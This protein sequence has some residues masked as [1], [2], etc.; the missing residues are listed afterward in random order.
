LVHHGYRIHNRTQQINHVIQAVNKIG[1]AVRG[2]Y[3]EGTEAL[4]NLFQISNQTTLGE[5]EEGIVDRLQKVILQVIEHEQNAR[6][7]LLQRRSNT[8][9]D[10][11]GRSYGILKHAYSM[12]SKE[13]LNLLS[14]AKLG[15]DLGFYPEEQRQAV[16]ELFMETQPAHLQKGSQQ[17]LA[18]EERDAL[19]ATIIRQ[20]LAACPEPDVL[21]VLERT[22]QAGGVLPEVG[23]K[24]EGGETGAPP[25]EGLI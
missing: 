4:G 18:A 24:E 1:L 6:Q 11:M 15:C 12:H 14:L 5:T 23:G 19:R 21:G 25:Q 20:K 10:H 7:T 8:L 2:L 3:G 9:L 17:K 16:D 13:A 22:A